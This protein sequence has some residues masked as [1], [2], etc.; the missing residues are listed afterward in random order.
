MWLVKMIE[1]A[2]LA[3]FITLNTFATLNQQPVLHFQTTVGKFG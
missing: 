1:Q 2:A 3:T